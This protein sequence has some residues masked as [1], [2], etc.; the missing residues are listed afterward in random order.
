MENE[1]KQEDIG[2]MEIGEERNNKLTPK[3]VEVITIEVVD[4]KNKVGENVGQKLNLKVKHPDMPTHV[5]ISK[6][7]YQKANQL[8]ES[9]LWINQD[10]D[11]KLP[12]NSAIASLMRRIGIKKIDEFNGKTIDPTTDENGYIIAKG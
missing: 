2:N 12:F 6:V 4:V 11:G 7:K 1:I 5:D 8:K 10:S 3:L 9:A